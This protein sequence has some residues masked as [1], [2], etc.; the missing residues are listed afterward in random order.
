VVVA[1][2]L[3]AEEALKFIQKNRSDRAGLLNDLLPLARAAVD[4]LKDAGRAATA[5]TLAAKIFEIDVLDEELHGK[6]SANPDAF[7]RG[8][9]LGVR[10]R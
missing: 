7:L 1:N 4:A 10:G 2:P 5:S 9:M 8:L 6:V 3:E